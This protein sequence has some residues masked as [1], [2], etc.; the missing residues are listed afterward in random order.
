MPISRTFISLS[1]KTFPLKLD[2]VSEQKYPENLVF[3][4]ALASLLL[5]VFPKSTKMETS[6]LPWVEKS[7][8][9]LD[10]TNKEDE[11]RY[12]EESV[13]NLG[14]A[15]SILEE[16]VCSVSKMFK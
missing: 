6:S 8:V 1:V 2:I 12:S 4:M 16:L 9:S 10:P 15:I 3:P 14:G 13:Q 7:S 11:F 5:A